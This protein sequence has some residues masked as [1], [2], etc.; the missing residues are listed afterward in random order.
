MIEIVNL[1]KSY[2]EVL[3]L[4]YIWDCTMHSTVTVSHCGLN[5]SVISKL[6]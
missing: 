5:K 2:K 4:L 3:R 1:H 6:V